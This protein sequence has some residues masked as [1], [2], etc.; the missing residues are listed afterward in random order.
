MTIRSSLVKNLPQE[1]YQ[2]AYSLN[3]RGKGFSRG[4]LRDVR[5]GQ[6]TFSRLISAW[7][8]KRLLGWCLLVQCLETEHVFTDILREYSINLYVRRSNRRA[9]VGRQLF[10]QCVRYLNSHHNKGHVCIWSKDSEGFYRSV[11]SPRIRVIVSPRYK[12]K[13]T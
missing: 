11:K 12:E 4:H 9:G 13:T 7:E 8:H 3:R 10:G 1:Q 2:A 6:H 5:R